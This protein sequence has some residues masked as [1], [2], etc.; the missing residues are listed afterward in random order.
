M[1]SLFDRLLAYYQISQKD[2]EKLVAPISEDDFAM[3]HAFKVI[4]LIALNFQFALC[5]NDDSMIV[6]PHNVI[7]RITLSF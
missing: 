7:M 5:E 2:Y 3:G 1:E 6:Y 4:W